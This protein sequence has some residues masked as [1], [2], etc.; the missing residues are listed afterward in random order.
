LVQSGRAEWDALIASI[1]FNRM[2]EPGAAGE[3]SAKDVIAHITWHEKEMVGVVQARALVGS[4]L[5][6]KPLDV[7]NA[8]IHEMNSGRSL[9]DVLAETATV[10]AQLLPLLQT[11]GDED[12]NDAGRFAG[13]PP[14]WQPWSVI[15]GNTYEHY[16]Q[17]MP[18]I[19]AWLRRKVGEG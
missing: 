5:W 8:A 7:R 4:E 3:W 14:A 18:A 13:M 12:L 1:P 10:Y 9:E 2:A 6:Q 19:R 17:H 11:L 15:A 16:E